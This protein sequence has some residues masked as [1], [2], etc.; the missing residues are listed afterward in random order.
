MVFQKPKILTIN[1]NILF[2]N[3]TY[4]AW[5][6]PFYHSASTDTFLNPSIPWYSYD[7]LQASDT[8]WWQYTNPD[9]SVGY[10]QT[11][12]FVSPAV[13]A[14][15]NIPASTWTL[16]IWANT[17]SATNYYVRVTIYVW[18]SANA[19][20]T[21][22][23][24][25]TTPGGPVSST[26]TA[27]TYNLSGGAVTLNPGDRIVI[28]LEVETGTHSDSP[29][30][31]YYWGT[32]TYDSKL[33]LP[34][35]ITFAYP[36][37][38]YGHNIF[39]YSGIHKPSPTDETAEYLSAN[40]HVECNDCHNPHAAKAGSYSNQAHVAARSNLISDSGPLTGAQ[41]VEPT[42]S[43]TNWGGTSAWPTTT[44]PATKEY[45][46][47]FKCHAG[48]NTN[49]YAWGGAAGYD[50]WT[51]VALEFNPNNKSY[52][53]VVQAL[54]PSQQLPPAFTSLVIGDSGKDQSSNSTSITIDSAYKS[55]TV[56]QWV[57]WGLRIGGFYCT[58]G[59]NPVYNNIRRIASN[60]ATRLTVDTPFSGG[61]IESGYTT[62]SIEYYAGRASSS[63]QPGD[64]KLGLTVT[65]SSKNFGLYLPSLAGYVVV[66]SDDL[67]N[68]LAKGTVTSNDATSFTVDNWTVLNGDTPP[69]GT[70][71]YY[72]SA[73]GHTMM[74]SDCHGNDTISSNAASGP[75]GSAV[76]WM[77]KG[78]NRA[79]PTNSAS[80][81]GHG[82]YENSGS[83]LY[84]LVSV[85]GRSTYTDGTPNGLFCLNCHSTITF[86]K[87]ANGLDSAD[88]CNNIH[89]FHGLFACVSCHTMV[90][91]GGKISR[92]IGDGDGN[93]PARY[94][95]NNDLSNMNVYSFLKAPSIT[96]YQTSN[97]VASCH[98]GGVG[99][100]D[101]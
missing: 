101:W 61:T 91:H 41:G 92:L 27:Y 39:I 21:V 75:H 51:D 58:T 36:P 18:T 20:G 77:L 5:P 83:S 45:Q 17:T 68:N 25:P 38:A 94:A 88:A 86:T 79:W 32:S 53:P 19:K 40:K 96:S 95:F 37:P 23:L 69:N 65:D 59:G 57:N 81:N 34:A 56:N 1:T 100:E 6:A 22:I 74:C 80:R 47:C 55:W 52:H 71:G 44:S 89:G 54:S 14:T 2:L 62:Y 30:L 15:T 99:G 70:V 78:R 50:A 43:A 28:E 60:T 73:T 8:Y 3:G 97:C 11:A 10:W 82:I 64:G 42:W 33:T 24:A 35:N 90:P 98:T 12:G 76:K 85:N 72:F 49:F 93:M 63:Y 48:Y 31:V 9:T 66:V 29:S 7:M 84:Q 4:A 26:L 87:D 13:A 67:G 16:R 46:I